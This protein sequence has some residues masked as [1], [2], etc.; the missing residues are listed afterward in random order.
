MDADALL[1]RI[2][3]LKDVDGFHPYNLGRLAQRNPLLRPCTPYGIIKLLESIDYPFKTGHATVIGASNIVGRPMAFELLLAGS[4]VSICHR[5][6]DDLKSHVELADLLV[7]ATGKRGVVKPEWIKPGCVVIDVGI[8]RLDD[9]RMVGDLD[10]DAVAERAGHMTPVPGGVGPMTV[11][12]LLENTWLAAEL[13]AI[14][15]CR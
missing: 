8:H 1:E 13:Q 15:W 2:H 5:F 7:V 10:F 3:P 6:T 12:M 9:G 14:K 4:T 11:T